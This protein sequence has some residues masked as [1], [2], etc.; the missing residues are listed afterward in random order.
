MLQQVTGRFMGPAFS[1]KAA[2][3]QPRKVTITWKSDMEQPCHTHFGK[4]EETV[5]DPM[6]RI[7][8]VLL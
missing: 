3:L 8:Y 4:K 7:V 5:N 2:C 1:T 6:P